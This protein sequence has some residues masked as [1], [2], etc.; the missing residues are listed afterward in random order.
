M[1][2]KM[3]NCKKHS[4]GQ[5]DGCLDAVDTLSYEPRQLEAT[6]ES[7]SPIAIEEWDLPNWKGF[8]VCLENLN[9]QKQV[10][11]TWPAQ[12]L[13]RYTPHQT[14]SNHASH[15]V[16]F[17]S[18]DQ[19]WAR[20]SISAFPD[21][22]WFSCGF[23]S[24]ISCE[25]S[26]CWRCVE[27]RWSVGFEGL[28]TKNDQTWGP[29]LTNAPQKKNISL[30]IFWPVSL[31]PGL[32]CPWSP[33]RIR[34]AR[35]RMWMRPMHKHQV[36]GQ[37][38]NHL[39]NPSRSAGGPKATSLKM[40]WRPSPRVM[41][42]PMATWT[43]RRRPSPTA[44][45]STMARRTQTVGQ[46]RRRPR[47]RRRGSHWRDLQ[48][49][50]ARP[51]GREKRRRRTRLQRLQ[52]K[53]ARKSTLRKAT[54]PRRG[55]H[56]FSEEAP[57]N[58][59]RT[60]DPKERGCKDAVLRDQEGL[61]EVLCPEAQVSVDF[62]IAVLCAVHEGVCGWEDPRWSPGRGLPG[63]SGTSSSDLLEDGPCP[64]LGS[65]R[66]WKTER[67]VFT[68]VLLISSPNLWPF[69][70]DCACVALLFLGSRLDFSTAVTSTERVS[71]ELV[72]DSSTAYT[73]M[74]FNHYKLSLLRVF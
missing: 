23:S 31:P 1:S 68:W 24:I 6:G 29:A 27:R 7:W 11:S 12:A 18:E 14:C 13:N 64:L 43:W 42:T 47:A 46:P 17:S 35:A 52:R 40:P 28:V 9:V 16:G 5:G 36:N 8:W 54:V 45:T 57:S 21:L 61:W 4:T 69:F 59:G 20:A 56:S 32:R 67:Y 48:P 55:G 73:L 3:C 19:F 50:A 2:P 33:A 53:T 30:L 39:L 44:W 74:L 70:Q 60:V 25:Y 37:Q 62:G 15:M 41:Q 58:M 72:S 34:G 49:E 63:F 65:E 51:R 10:D 71:V 22:S 38:K 66:L 26:C